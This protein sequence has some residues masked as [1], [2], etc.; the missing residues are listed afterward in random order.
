MRRA[1]ALGVWSALGGGAALGVLLGGLLTAGPGWPWVFYVNVPI[2]LAI[3]AA[4]SRMLPRHSAT[5]SRGGLDV[6]GA[7][8][9]TASSGAVIFALVNA[10]D[11]GWLSATNLWLV[12]LAAAGYLAFVVWQKAARAPLMD[13]ALLTRRPVT[14]GTFLS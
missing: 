12:A 5:A 14:T 1:S 2:G 10:G 7:L 6:F 8:L 3:M 4:L 9:V 13:V 11:E